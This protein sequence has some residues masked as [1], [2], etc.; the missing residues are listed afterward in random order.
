[1]ADLEKIAR[2]RVVVEPLD[3]AN[4]HGMWRARCTHCPWVVG[5][6]AKT[7]L[8]GTE[9]RMH[10]DAHREGRA[11]VCGVAVVLAES[12]T[13]WTWRCACG[14]TTERG[15]HGTPFVL[16]SADAV[17]DAIAHGHHGPITMP[18]EVPVAVV[19]TIDRYVNAAR[20]DLERAYLESK[21]VA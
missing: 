17:L 10:R 7:W 14:A 9:A 4:R 20:A 1:M 12:G 3:P 6:S 21:A 18:A 19:Q 2:P 5:P 15:W 13:D 16:A 8:E 11:V